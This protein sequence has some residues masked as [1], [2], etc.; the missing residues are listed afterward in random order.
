MLKSLSSSVRY[1]VESDLKFF[2][3]PSNAINTFLFCAVGAGMLVYAGR[4]AEDIR[5]ERYI[6]A[7]EQHL[8]GKLEQQPKLQDYDPL[9]PLARTLHIVK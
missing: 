3:K 1:F 6:S 2:S 9:L 5:D 7:L 4:K 8:S